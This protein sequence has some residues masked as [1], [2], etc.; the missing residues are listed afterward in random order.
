MPFFKKTRR[1]LR[2]FVSLSKGTEVEG[3]IADISESVALRGS[4]VWMLLCSS[5]LASI[6]LDLNSSAVII[7]AMLISPL[8][9]PIL[10]TGLGVAILDRK[11]LRNSLSNLALATTLSLFTSFV[12]FLI[13]PFG[14]LTSE[15]SARTTPTI[16]DAAIAFF[17]G[18][19]GVVAGSRSKKTSAVPGVAIATALMP[20]VCT[21]GYGL[22]KFSSTIFLGAFYL[23]FLNA[24]L[25]SLA[26]YLMALWLRFPKR[27][28]LDSGQD[29]KRKALDNCLLDP[30]N[31]PK[32]VHFL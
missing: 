21:A 27:T 31:Y 22:A 15:L 32:R 1:L 25:I 18:I 20:P 11:L 17:G 26:T 14:E 30:G 9:S 23:Y 16:L 8:M 2:S 12:Y 28:V 6:G 7:G 19:A 5:I 10:G 4:T 3:T 29:S 24:F 13:S